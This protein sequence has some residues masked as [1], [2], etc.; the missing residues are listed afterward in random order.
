[1]ER[2]TVNFSSP[3]V[4]LR[5]YAT[6]GTPEHQAMLRVVSAAEDVI[7][8]ESAVLLALIEH[9]HAEVEQEKLRML[10]DEAYSAAE[11]D[12][13]AADAMTALESDYAAY[14]EGET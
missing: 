7:N 1:M 14:V 12:T 6:P 2:K 10:Y 11:P 4:W 9:A 3:P 8:S 13:D 5:R